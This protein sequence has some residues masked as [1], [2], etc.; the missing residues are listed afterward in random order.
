MLE[1]TNSELGTRF[2]YQYFFLKKKS[3]QSEHLVRIKKSYDHVIGSYEVLWE[4]EYIF[5]HMGAILNPEQSLFLKN[6]KNYE[7]FLF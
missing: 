2:L 4:C 7:Y 5:K 6:L 1:I 3:E